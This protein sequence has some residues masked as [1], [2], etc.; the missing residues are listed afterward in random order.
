MHISTNIECFVWE[1]IDYKEV[2]TIKSRGMANS[3]TATDIMA[4]LFIKLP[5]IISYTL[6]KQSF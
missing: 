1:V 4:E 2:G 6:R 5:E 3:Y